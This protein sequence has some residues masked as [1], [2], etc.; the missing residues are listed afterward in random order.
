MVAYSF[1]P[2]FVP[3]ICLG[4]GLPIPGRLG[5]CPGSNLDDPKIHTIRAHR[6]GRS[7]H[8]RPGETLQLYCRQRLPDGFLIGKAACETVQPITIMFMPPCSAVSI[9]GREDDRPLDDFAR[10]DGFA[11]WPD[12]VDFW[13]VHHPG[14]TTFSGVIITWKAA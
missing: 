5:S 2:M 10:A 11:S 3:P 9:D 8:A 13:R 4:L 1:Q 14:V 7:R 12:L 6:R